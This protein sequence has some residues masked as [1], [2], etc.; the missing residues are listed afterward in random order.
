MGWQQILGWVIL[1]GLFF[2]GIAY[3]QASLVAHY[4][5][6]ETRDPQAYFKED[7]LGAIR[8]LWLRHRVLLTFYVAILFLSITIIFAVSSFALGA[9]V[10]LGWFIGLAGFAATEIGLYKAR[11]FLQKIRWA[12]NPTKYWAE[13]ERPWKFQIMTCPSFALP[14]LMI[15]MFLQRFVATS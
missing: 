10:Y 14:F 15:Y 7:T 13:M 12:R 11:H 2:P 8:G 4:S 3:G 6:K 5:W 1:W 9:P